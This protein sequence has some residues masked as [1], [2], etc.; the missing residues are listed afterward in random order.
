MNS[1]VEMSV[2]CR[3]VQ[4]GCVVFPPNSAM[5]HAE[6]VTCYSHITAPE[7]FYPVVGIT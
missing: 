4:V 7:F 5:V 1:A 6:R 2:Y 3:L